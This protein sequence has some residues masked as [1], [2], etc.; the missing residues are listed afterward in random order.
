MIIPE[1]YDFSDPAI[2]N[3]VDENHCPTEE[4]TQVSGFRN[5]ELVCEKDKQAWPCPIIQARRAYE[6]PTP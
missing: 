2:R 4:Y 6:E 1:N 3:L 5:V